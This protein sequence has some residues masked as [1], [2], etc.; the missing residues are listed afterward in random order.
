M[1]F[2]KVKYQDTKA[3]KKVEVGFHAL[4]F[5]LKFSHT[6]THTRKKKSNLYLNEILCI[7]SSTELYSR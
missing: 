4:K 1:K 5:A 3:Y 2:F 7:V 6:S